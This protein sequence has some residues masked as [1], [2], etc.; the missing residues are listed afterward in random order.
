MVTTSFSAHLSKS[1][2]QHKTNG[3]AFLH[4]QPAALIICYYQSTTAQLASRRVKFH[5][6]RM[7]ETKMHSTNTPTAASEQ[8]LH[9]AHLPDMRQIAY[10]LQVDIFI[11]ALKNEWLCVLHL[12]VFCKPLFDTTWECSSWC[13]DDMVK[14]ISVFFLIEFY[15]SVYITQ[16]FQIL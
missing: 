3:S 13:T 10:N 4:I 5:S 12:R 15:P 1:E 11:E 9:Y 6:S 8:H 2:Y 14:P 7:I 16:L